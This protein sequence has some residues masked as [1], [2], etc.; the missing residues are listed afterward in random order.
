MAGDTEADLRKSQGLGPFIR[1]LLWD[2][3]DDSFVDWDDDDSDARYCAEGYSLY[4]ATTPDIDITECETAYVYCSS[5]FTSCGYTASKCCR[6]KKYCDAASSPPSSKSKSSKKKSKKSK[7]SKKKCKK[8]CGKKCFM[9]S[10]W[11][12]NKKYYRCN[13]EC[14]Y[15]KC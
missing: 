12:Q 4:C 1:R 6:Q 10:G 13:G 14:Q 15:K 5:G 9:K 8:K 3:H 7:K 2:P 11:R